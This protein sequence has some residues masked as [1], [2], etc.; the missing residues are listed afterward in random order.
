MLPSFPPPPPPPS[1]PPFRS[2]CACVSARALSSSQ[3]SLQVDVASIGF[4]FWISSSLNEAAA[5]VVWP[6]KKPV[7]AKKPSIEIHR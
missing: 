3:T 6:F 2:Y 1:S 5:S 7:Y 4:Q